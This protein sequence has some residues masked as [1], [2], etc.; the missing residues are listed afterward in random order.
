MKMAL[1]REFYIPRE[2]QGRTNIEST[3]VADAVIYTYV[4]TSG[5]LGAMAFHGKAAKPDWHYS[6]R[7]EESRQRK[8]AEYIDGRKERAK[9]MDDIKA[10]RTAPHTLKVGDI[11][12]SSWGYDQ[13]NIDYYQVVRVVG[14]HSVEIR[15]LVNKS[16]GE[17]GFMTGLVSPVRDHF[18]DE[19][20]LK[21]CDAGNSVRIESYAS[22]S[23]WDGKPDRCSWYA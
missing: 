21:R 16:H 9:M 7:N 18:K 23:M 8:I 15:Q 6:F 14:A 10:K 5:Q 11:L 17:D 20:M 13:T 22:A 12:V 4:T 3:Q 2:S 19:P 1:Q